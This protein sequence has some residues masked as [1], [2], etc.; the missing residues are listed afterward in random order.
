MPFLLII[1]RIAVY[2][3]T[4]AWLITF[5]AMLFKL[6][7]FCFFSGRPKSLGLAIGFA[8]PNFAEQK[9]A[10]APKIA[11]EIRALGIKYDE[12]FNKHDADA[13][14][15]LYTQDAVRRT[16]HGTFS[17]RPAIEKNYAQYAFQQYHANNFVT[18]VDQ[19]N[20]VGNDVRAT[21]KWS[22]AFQKYSTHHVEG[23][24]SWDLVR[25]GDTWKIRTMTYDNSRG[26]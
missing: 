20:A 14:G 2:F 16:P 19:V 15:A 9:D 12:A 1:P 4:L 13:L 21:G 25:V 6:A 7:N 3:A 22:C 8:L 17:G 18:T 24:F 26:Y 23:H 11:Q 10:G 5:C